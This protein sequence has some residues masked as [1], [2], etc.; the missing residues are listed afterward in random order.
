MKGLNLF[1]AT[2]FTIPTL[3]GAGAETVKNTARTTISRTTA[4][5]NNA[6]NTNVKLRAQK[7][8]NTTSGATQ[9]SVVSRTG[10]TPTRTSSSVTSRGGGTSQSS[11]TSNVISRS[12]TTP[13]HTVARTA[14]S[15]QHGARRSTGAA[16]AAVKT[17]ESVMNRDFGKCKTVFFECMDEFC[18]NKDAQLKR[19]ACSALKNEF[20][21]TQKSLDAVEN[22]LVDFSQ[23]LL[24]VNMDPADAAVINQ[25]TAGEQAYNATK[26]KSSAKRTLDEIAGKLNNGF[27]SAE[28]GGTGLALSWSLG[29][30][31]AFD[32]V[33]SLSGIA[34][35]A[36]SGTALRNAALPICSEMAAEVCDVEDISLVEISYNMAIEQDCNTVKRAYD[37][38]V[39]NAR[40][41]VLDSGALL[42]MTRLST[43]QDNNSDDVISCKAK[44][45]DILSSP[46]VCGTDLVQCL[47]ISG[48]YI[49]PATGSA[50]LTPQLVNL[51]TLI[52]RPIGN[53]TW[54]TMAGNEPF[55]THLNSKKK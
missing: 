15:T 14:T 35:T 17:R 29:A 4:N 18:A 33:D 26:D 3:S 22:N 46:S 2:L 51:A 32:T 53:A 52:V 54:S 5:T 7:N 47:D 20:Q 25:E 11:R 9:K 16:R 45:L 34:T 49:N 21:S 10:A 55:V 37:T 41:K 39:Q 28:N 38:M 6:R 24:K 31:T 42:D 43:Y 36:K 44:M 23:R 27:T 19:C 8:A 48:Q 50:F 40:T 30:D 12:A 13:T 1:L